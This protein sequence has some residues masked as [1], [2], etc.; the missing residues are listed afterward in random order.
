MKKIRILRR[1]VPSF[2]N[3]CI[4]LMKLTFLFLMIGLIQ[5]SAS[6]YSQ[7][8]KLTLKMRDAKVA[9]VLDAIENQSEFRFA[10][11]SGYIDLDRKLSVDIREKTVEESLNV[12][13]EGTDV[14]FAIRDRHILLFPTSLKPGTN[15]IVAHSVRSVGSYQQRT[16]SGKVTDSGGEPLPG[17]SIVIKGTT[18]GTVT[19]V[20]GNY[21]LTDVSSDA[22]LVFSFVGMR[23]Q[24]IVVGNQTSINVRM[25]KDVIGI[26]E[27]VAIG[28]GTQQKI[29]VIG[30][31]TTVSNEEISVSPVSN[32]SN[33]IAGRLPGLVVQQ[34]SGE[35]GYNAAQLKIRG[36]ATLGNKSPLVVVDGVP[37]RD[38]NSLEASD[39]ENITILKDASAGIY[40]AR[41][42]NGVILVTTRQGTDK[43]TLF[44]FN[45]YQGWETPTKLPKMADAPTYAQLIREVETYRG[46]AEENLQFSLEDI[47][48]YESGE[49]PW[50][51]PN[52]NWVTAALKDYTNT[53][54][55]SFKVSGGSEDF[56]YYTSFSKHSDNGIYKA[57][58][59]EFDRYNAKVN[60]GY[61]LLNKHLTIGLDINASQEDR[62]YP[63]KSANQIFTAAIRNKPTQPAYWPNGLPGPDIEYGDQPVT[64][65]S[66]E[67]GFSDDKRY[68]INN[69][70]RF[71]LKIPNI[72]GLTLSGHYAY[73]M[74]FQVK[75]VFTKPVTLYF[76]DKQAYLAAGNTG[77]EDGS[78]FLSGV[79]RGTIDEPRLTDYYNDSKTTTGYLKANYEKT[80]NEVHNIEMFIAAES[81]DYKYKGINAFRR[82]FLSD[83]LPYLFA[84]GTEEMSNGSDI[85]IDARLNY[86]GR[87]TYNYNE[88]YLLEFTFRRDGSLR[89]SKDAG[90]W[91][92]FPSVLLGWRISDENFWENNLDF[93][94]YL[95]L[96]ASYGQM[97]NDAVSAFQYLTSYGFGTGMVFGSGRTYSSSLVQRGTPNPD[98]TWEIAN[99]Y[100]VGFESYFLDSR[101]QLDFDAFYQRR[102]Q[103]LVQRQAS[104]PNFT[105]ISLPDENFGIVDNKGFEVVLGYNNKAGNFAYS[106]NGNLAFNRN[107]I[108]EYDEPERNVPWQERTG[109]PIGAQLLYKYIGVFK[110]ETHVESYPHVSGARPGDIIIEDYDGDGEITS[111]DQILFDKTGDPEITYG[112][113]LSLTYKNFQLNSLIQGVGNTYARMNID[114]RAGLDGNYLNYYAEGRWTEDNPNADKPRIFMRLEEYWRSPYVTNYDYNNLAFA[115]LKNLELSYTIPVKNIQ[116]ANWLKDAKIYASGQNLFFLYQDFAW[117][118]DP[119]IGSMM[120]YPLMKTYAIGL[121]IAF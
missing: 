9:E 50:T 65:S 81:R 27:V 115:R 117:D 32:V 31:M 7:T 101:F 63:T 91:G 84:G 66:F 83:K 12:I 110:D 59:T 49:Y 99:V 22:T 19:D 29:N 25:E 107:K 103:I 16:V 4:R 113:T 42:A 92:N 62:M 13:F 89:F 3:K 18:Q 76:L 10:Y 67:T 44:E 37:E 2:W 114:T 51:H 23:T 94:D 15:T 17:V 28:Y 77:K 120:N 75:K 111:D 121:K 74:Y 64:S 78:E 46:V 104:V 60:I 24:E 36:N 116:Y 90:R 20:E 8:A 11:S 97:G 100:N 72:E 88:K 96:R 14:E 61:S 87:F 106:I 102:S 21:S 34:S 38:L 73:D 98:I 53:N 58:S 54:H 86:F 5:V 82:Y 1:K 118:A 35:P 79:Q 41:A 30:S 112:I 93:V 109:H 119:E 26:D 39:I 95:K 68:R 57:N 6:V 43:P 48:K 70:L 69:L 33:T 56:N 55:L 80:I 47:E 85:N 40:G 105:G 52:T 45:T 108:I 71:N